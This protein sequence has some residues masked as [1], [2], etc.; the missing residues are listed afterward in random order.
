MILDQFGRELKTTKRPERREIAVV[1]VRDRWSQYPSDGLTPVRLAGI[2]KEADQGDVY[3]QM[4][5]FEEMEEKDTHLSAELLKRKNGVNCLDFDVIPY[6]EGAKTSAY[7]KKKKAE[8]DKVT[9]FCRDVIFSMTSFEESL[10]DLL[11]AIGKGFSCSW[12][13]WEIDGGKAV[14]SDLKWIHQ[15]RFS[16]VESL[17]PKLMTD[18]NPMGE[19]IG[20]FQCVY[21][22]HKAR[23]GHDTRA[24][25]IRVCAWMYLFKN[26]AIKDWVAFAEVFG[27]PL[28][29]GKYDSGAG[30]EDKDALI[31][32]IQS[33]G[34]DAAG[35][36]SKATE[37]E[38]I[39][40]VKGSTKENVYKTLADFTNTEISKAVIGST[41]TTDVGERG[42]YAASKTHNDVRMDLVK[43]DCWSL[44]NTIRNQILRPLV[45]YNFGW[46]TPVP[47]FK[48]YLEE[49]EDLKA[50]ME[51]YK[52]ASEI[53][54]PITAEH[55]S[56]RFGIALPEAGQTILQPVGKIAMKSRNG[57][58]AA[59]TGFVPG[60]LSRIE[61]KAD[62]GPVFDAR[63]ME[64]ED[65]ADKA[66]AAGGN[67]GLDGPVKRLIASCNS[68]EEVRDRIFDLYG[69]MA[70]EDLTGL[71]KDALVT[72]AIKGMAEDTGGVWREKP[73]FSP[74]LT[75]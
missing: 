69:D 3:R 16:F 26:Y 41:L 11:D 42:S 1:G 18:D 63:Q 5:L 53:G 21:H 46:E 44:S 59:R 19:E 37:I 68:L 52:G 75:T 35:I 20:P 66:L 27:M 14:I 51:V 2:L 60:I 38:F 62:D 72:A 43:S 39:E 57:G 36:I 32:A 56:E 13:K 10:F 64:L 15:K 54:Q 29:L 34:S 71:L 50:L 48:F 49:P 24:G 22:R 65:L 4:E 23:S 58:V 31:A 47:W 33:L 8:N 67:L 73:K 6:E 12:I 61:A 55:V 70:T 30:Q 17:T 7:R 40:T 45:G 74:G 28:R 9:D 25:M